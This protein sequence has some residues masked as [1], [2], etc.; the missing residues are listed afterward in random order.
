[1]LAAM[2]IYFVLRVFPASTTYNLLHSQR[3]TTFVRGYLTSFHFNSRFVF[4]DIP[5]YSL[6][7]FPCKCCDP[8]PRTSRDLWF[9]K[10]VVAPLI[11]IYTSLCSCWILMGTMLN[12]IWGSTVALIICF[13]LSSFTNVVSCYER[14]R[15]AVQD[16]TLHEY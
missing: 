16:E 1:M 6:L 15:H 14:I 11:V 4:Y 10:L 3:R 12:L 2:G 9:V 5:I 8:G 13:T 7:P